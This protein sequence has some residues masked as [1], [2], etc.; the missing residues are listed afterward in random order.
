MSLT[1]EGGDEHQCGGPQE[2]CL[3]IGCAE[4][5]MTEA[6]LRKLCED[7]QTHI[8]ESEARAPSQ[9]VVGDALSLLRDIHAWLT[10]P[11][12]ETWPYHENGHFA[13]DKAKVIN[14]IAAL[15]PPPSRDG[16]KS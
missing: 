5:G 4:C 14:R 11:K 9:P 13:E 16:D 1:T 15:T 3:H 10:A 7:L 2:S 12:M 8:D 6:K